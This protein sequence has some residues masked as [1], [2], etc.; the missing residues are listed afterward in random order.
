MIML[1]VEEPD[2]MHNRAYRRC[3]EALKKRERMMKFIY[4]SADGRTLT[5]QMAMHFSLHK[6]LLNSLCGPIR[7]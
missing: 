1:L 3:I 7:A 2:G 6:T 5:T 4:M